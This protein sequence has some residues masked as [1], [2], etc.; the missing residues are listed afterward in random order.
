MASVGTLREIDGSLLEIH[1]N[2]A[3]ALPSASNITQTLHF[4]TLVGSHYYLLRPE[5]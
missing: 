4:D 3:Y 5:Q 1:A 2:P